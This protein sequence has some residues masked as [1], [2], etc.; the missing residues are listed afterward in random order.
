MIPETTEIGTPAGLSLFD[1]RKR[2]LQEVNRKFMRAMD[3]G[4]TPPPGSID[5]ICMAQA[6]LIDTPAATLADV[7]FKIDLAIGEVDEL[8]GEGESLALLRRAHVALLSGSASI[9]AR[10]LTLAMNGET[11]CEFAYEGAAAALDD[12]RRLEG[13]Q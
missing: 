2:Y 11:D 1:A 9:A 12:L 13:A 8:G 3:E 10:V 5:A 7:A 6:D 4:R